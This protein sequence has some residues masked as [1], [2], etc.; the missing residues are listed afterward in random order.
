MCTVCIIYDY[1]S[2]MP[3]FLCQTPSLG[4]WYLLLFYS[5]KNVSILVSFLKDEEMLTVQLEPHQIKSKPKYIL[6]SISF[7]PL[8]YLMGWTLGINKLC[9]CS[10]L[11]FNQK[12]PAP[13]VLFILR[14]YGT[15]QKKKKKK[16]VN[17]ANQHSN[18]SPVP[19]TD[20]PRP[21]R[22]EECLLSW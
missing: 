2:I 5:L 4:V 12:M 18:M 21:G 19:R 6:I 3:C 7:V 14:N 16:K 1:F 9:N 15:L 10:Q 17:R 20:S 11:P 8:D 22:L 13:N